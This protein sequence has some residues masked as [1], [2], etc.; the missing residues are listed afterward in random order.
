MSPV[1]YG[2]ILAELLAVTVIDLRVERIS[3]FWALA[4]VLGAG[5]LYLLLPES[6]VWSFRVLN[7][8]ICFLVLGFLLFLA[9]IMGAGDSKFLSSLFLLLPL[10][11][12]VPF[13]EALL[14]STLVIGAVL[15][16]LKVL[17]NFSAARAHVLTGNWGGFRQTI[18]SR[19]SYGPVI[20]VAWVLL[21][22]KLWT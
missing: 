9:K 22:I 5:L 3:N 18:A 13:F 6:Y 12:H 4:N 15:F 21:G 1:V 10:G 17:R 20:L 7:F 8:P 19:F 2:A 14:L 11:F 16:A